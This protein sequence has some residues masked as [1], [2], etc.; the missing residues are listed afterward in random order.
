[1]SSLIKNVLLEIQ[2]LKGA[3]REKI[4]DLLFDAE[5]VQSILKP[6][7]KVRFPN[8]FRYPD[9]IRHTRSNQHMFV[10]NPRVLID[11]FDKIFH[12]VA[13]HIGGVRETTSK[14]YFVLF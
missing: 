14:P 12:F 10:R 13:V 1:M 5:R 7:N 11:G 6:L 4:G 9:D 2:I 8:I 3:R